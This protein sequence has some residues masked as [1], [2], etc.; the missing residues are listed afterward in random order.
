LAHR[1]A[2]RQDQLG[3]IAATDSGDGVPKHEVSNQFIDAAVGRIGILN[4]IFHPRTLYPSARDIVNRVTIHASPAV[5]CRISP[6]AA[7]AEPTHRPSPRP[8]RIRDSGRLKNSHATRRCPWRR[9]GAQPQMRE[10]ALDHRGCYDRRD[11]LQVTAALRAAFDV[12]VECIG[13]SN[14]ILP[15]TTVTGV[16]PFH[17]GGTQA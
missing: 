12:D 15:M 13:S 14:A 6:F 8:V 17:S 16:P 11:D 5:F 9:L 7:Q 10:Y 1:T 3:D 4:T 2:A